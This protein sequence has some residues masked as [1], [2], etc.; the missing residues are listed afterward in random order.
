[1][2]SDQSV[3]I[4]TDRYEKRN[5]I[6]RSMNKILTSIKAIFGMNILTEQNKNR[7]SVANL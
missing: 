7:D 3:L 1:M 5:V 6:N 4:R 2:Q